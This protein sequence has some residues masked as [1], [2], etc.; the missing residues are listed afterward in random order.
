MHVQKKRVRETKLI[1]KTLR[2]NTQILFILLIG[3]MKISL[4]RAVGTGMAQGHYPPPI[5]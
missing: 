4:S 3:L 1:S 2:A 5:F